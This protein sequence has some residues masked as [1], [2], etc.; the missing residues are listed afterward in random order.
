MPFAMPLRVISDTASNWEIALSVILVITASIGLRHIAIKV[1]AEAVLRG[2]ES[3]E[4]QK[5]SRDTHS[6]GWRKVLLAIGGA[7]RN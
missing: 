4:N 2:E 5:N 7:A 3:E 1:F 6:S